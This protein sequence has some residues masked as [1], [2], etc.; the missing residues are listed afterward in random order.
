MSKLN[1][2]TLRNQI[3]ALLAESKKKKRNFTET[4]ELQVGL[5]NYDPMKD[6]RFAG[7]SRLQKNVACFSPLSVHLTAVPPFL[8]FVSNL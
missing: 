8:A 1:G 6:K 7:A 5:K 3:D 4:I 2:E